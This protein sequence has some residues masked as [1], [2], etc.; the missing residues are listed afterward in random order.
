MARIFIV[1]GREHPD[2]DTSLGI[3]EVQKMLAD[4]YP[5]VATAEVRE[6]QR[7]QDTLV[8]FL[9]KVGTKG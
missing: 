6:T 9:K 5:E 7:G 1:D 2:P 8:E 3:P 4:F